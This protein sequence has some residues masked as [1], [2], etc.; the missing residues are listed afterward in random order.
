MRLRTALWLY[1]LDPISLA[2]R[3]FFGLKFKYQLPTLCLAAATLILVA[4]QWFW[5]SGFAFLITLVV[6]SQ[7]AVVKD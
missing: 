5:L 1:L 3:G 2:W 7:A 6:W 4:L